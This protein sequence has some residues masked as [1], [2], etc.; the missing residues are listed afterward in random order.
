M[1]ADLVAIVCDVYIAGL[2]VYAV[3]TWIPD[4]N[5]RRLGGWLA[6]FYEPALVYIRRYV[7]PVR[8]GGAMVDT[9]VIVYLV[10]LSIAR[11]LAVRLLGG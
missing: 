7:G 1:L 6:R 10:A 4:A 8:I 3:T 9:S 2:I 5:A 11:T